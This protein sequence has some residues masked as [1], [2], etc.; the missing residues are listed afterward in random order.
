MS[1]IEFTTRDGSASVRGTERAYGAAL[2]ARLTAAIL[3]LDGQHTQESNRRILPDIFFLQADFNAQRH[4]RAVSLTDAFT[5]WAPMAGMMYED[6]SA[7]IRIGDKT[8]RPDGFVINTAVVA[9]SDP[10]ALLTRIHA[11]SEEGL[12]VAGMDRSWL[13][14]II[15]VGLQARILRDKAG[16]GSAAE[17]LRADGR[18]PA[19]ITISQG[20]SPSWLQGAAAGFYADGQGDQERRAAENAFEAL[21]GGEQWDRSISALLEERRPDASWWLMLDPETFHK[22]SH[23]ELLTAFDAIEADNEGKNAT[24]AERA[25]R[26]LR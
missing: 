17:L 23:L 9:G 5:Y 26:A 12:L 20:M 2:A 6:G 11:Y 13:A 7:D 3:E 16:W 8:E 21:S 10:I 15:D 19:L 25:E 4:G 1:G 14:G 18:S 22:P 24:K